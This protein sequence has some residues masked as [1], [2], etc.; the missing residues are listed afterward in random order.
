MFARRIEPEIELFL[1]LSP[2]YSPIK[3][4]RRG[5]KKDENGLA[6]RLEEKG[7]KICKLCQKEDLFSLLFKY[8]LKKELYRTLT[9]QKKEQKMYVC[10][11]P[12]ICKLRI[13]RKNRI[14]LCPLSLRNYPQPSAA[15]GK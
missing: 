5:D 4:E 6:S 2:S 8:M 15:F 11:M 12:A 7:G 3:R 14:S 1:P 13:M 9:T 10:L